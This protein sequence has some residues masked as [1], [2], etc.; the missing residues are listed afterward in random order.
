MKRFLQSVSFFALLN[1]IFFSAQAQNNFGVCCPFNGWDYV[2]PITVTNNAAA[3]TPANLQTVFII[4]TQTPISQGKMNANGDD[5]RFTDGN[6]GNYLPYYIETGMNTPNTNIWIRLPSIPSG[7]S[8]TIYIYYGNAAAASAAV[9]FNV[10]FPS[11]LTINAPTNL[12]GL[13]NYDWIDIQAGG[14][15][16]MPANG[17][18]PVFQARKIIFNG[19]FNGN[20]LGYA[21]QTGPGRGGNGAGSVG[22]GGGG[23]GGNGGTGGGAQGFGGAAYGTPTGPDIDKGSGGGGSDCAPTAAGG[24]AI[25]FIGSVLVMNGTIN[26]NGQTAQNCC[27]GNSSEAAGGGAGGGVLLEADYITGTATINARGGNGGNSDTKEGGGGGAGGRVKVRWVNND[28]FTGTAAV[29]GGANGV[30]GQSGQQPGQAGTFQRPQIQ[31]LTRTPGTEVPVSIPTADFTF[32]NV[33][34][35]TNAAFTDASTVQSGGS[36]TQ[37]AWDFGDGAT[38]IT[39]NPTHT[40]TA[41]NTYNVSL[42][43]TSVTGCTNSVTNQITVSGLPTADFVAPSVCENNPTQFTDASPG[44]PTQWTWDFGD[45]NSDNVQNP[46]HTYSGAGTYNVTLTVATPANC[47]NSVTKSVTVVPAPV[48]DFTLQNVCLNNQN[49]FTDAST[50]NVGAI[51]Q[52]AWDFGDGSNA[53]QQNPSHTYSADGI[54]NVTLTVTSVNGCPNSITKQAIVHPLPIAGFTVQPICRYESSDFSDASVINS[55]SITQWDWN[56][57]DNETSNQQNPSH[58]YAYDGSYT[59]TLTVTSDNGCTG[60]VTQSALVH[61]LPAVNFSVSNVCLGF[62]ANFN[63][64]STVALGSTINQWAWNFGDAGATA[65][66]QNPTYTYNNT[67]IYTVSLTTTTNNNCSSTATQTVSVFDNPEVSFNT[68]P[69]C[70]DESNGT[71]TAIASG[72]SGSYN[73]LWENGQQSANIYNLFAGDYDITVTDGNGCTA[74]GTASVTEYTV[75][76][77]PVATPDSQR[78]IFGDTVNVSISSNFD[79]NVVYSISPNYNISCN[80]CNAL[81]AFPNH[82]TVYTVNA[83]DTVTGCKGVTDFIVRV[84][85]KYIL[86]VPNAFTPNNDGVNDDIK[87]Y[88]KGLKFFHFRVF[89]RWGEMVFHSDDINQP[90]DGTYKGK[91]VDSGVYVYQV[92]L[93]YLNGVTKDAQGSIT[94][95]K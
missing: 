10:M 80:N 89:N 14:T 6:C 93:G 59:V 76:V 70:F 51:T 58:N 75:P 33:C 8:L 39:Q 83:T 41:A 81:F 47:S 52:W 11:V 2:M 27:C 13:Q 90:W 35:N 82:T 68:T 77:A 30:G 66:T 92:K 71:A 50:S 29:N 32:N 43:V 67:G 57:G 64:L 18:P 7:G 78:I 65:N 95:I 19:T 36:V 40:Y 45:G 22:G 25:S 24:G 28:G 46:I 63:D 16:T 23:Y 3:A 56:F 26:V 12:T 20:N 17:T 86:F 74:T 62:P 94:V 79:P 5:I 38:A 15:I 48:A 4:N 1:M 55:G 31:G 69:A 73:Y 21:P 60:S 44:N 84:D 72:G 87:V 49:V 88:S 91:I 42:T 37:W 85:E 61:P 9:T 53:S 54:Y 34:L